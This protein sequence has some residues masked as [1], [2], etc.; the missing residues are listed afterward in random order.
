MK[1]KKS[2]ALFLIALFACAY[3]IAP[4]TASGSGTISGTFK[5]STPPTIV[6]I[7]MNS[8]STVNPVP[9]ASPPYSITVRVRDSD[10]NADIRL[11]EAA[12]HEIQDNTK[13]VDY[14]QATSGFQII[15]PSTIDVIMVV[16]FHYYTPPG[17]Y[18]ITVT[19]T[20]SA[21]GTGTQTSSA[22]TYSSAIGL[23]ID[24]PST[25]NFG[26]LTYG[27][28]SAQ[29]I[30]TIHN[31]ANTNIFVRATALDWTSIP[32]GSNVPANTLSADGKQMNDPTAT[33]Q[34]P[35]WVQNE[36][37]PAGVPPHDLAFVETV[38]SQSGGFTLAG[39]YTTTI[40]LMA[41]SS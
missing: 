6:S 17:Q 20:D 29:Q 3:L 41:S 12:L 2:A 34:L 39:T 16:Y 32:A 26:T 18:A 13:E 37:Y 23:T 19:A 22:I 33:V 31:S 30:S 40:T 7:T 25:L 4:V 35:V 8:G 21:S 27:S 15:D 28:Q 5:S 36:Q 24:G 38:P 10:G 11:V 9:D 14:R 1:S